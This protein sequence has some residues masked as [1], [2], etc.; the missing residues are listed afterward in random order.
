MLESAKLKK[1]DINEVVMVGGSTRIPKVQ[2]MVKDY[3][4][5]DLLN[6]TINADEAIAA[7]A[8]LNCILSDEKCRE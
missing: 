6:K 5:K 3:M 8:T 7:G 2:K 1:E 4:G